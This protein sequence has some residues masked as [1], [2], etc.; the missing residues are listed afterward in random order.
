MC[1]SYRHQDV[2]LSLGCHQLE[3]GGWCDPFQRRERPSNGVMN[4][5]VFVLER[6]FN[7]VCCCY[8]YSELS[9]WYGIIESRFISSNFRAVY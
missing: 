2:T 9:N 8:K 7:H 6:P 4:Y 1:V 5:K 3:G